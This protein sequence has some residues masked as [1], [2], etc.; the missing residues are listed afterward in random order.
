MVLCDSGNLSQSR[1][2]CLLNHHQNIS[3]FKLQEKQLEKTIKC[4]ENLNRNHLLVI[5]C[6]PQQLEL[7]L[8]PY[9]KDTWTRIRSQSSSIFDVNT[10]ENDSKWLWFSQSQHEVWME[11]FFLWFSIS[12]KSFPRTVCFLMW[13]KVVWNFPE[14]LL[15]LL[16]SINV[17]STSFPL[18]WDRMNNCPF[19]MRIL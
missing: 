13:E 7:S 16:L 4:L 2:I 12:L 9:Y 18:C 6:S 11:F 8:L 5:V 3:E 19:W 10:K 17:K 14:F 15:Y 1:S